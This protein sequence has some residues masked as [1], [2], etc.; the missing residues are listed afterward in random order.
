MTEQNSHH[1]V[2]IDLGTTRSV[3]AHLD[4]TGRPLTI[5]N[6]EGDATTPSVVFFDRK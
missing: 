3:V 5:Q 1:A 6:Q 2:G 4:T